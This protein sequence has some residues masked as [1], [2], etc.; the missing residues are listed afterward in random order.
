MPE[1]LIRDGG[2]WLRR[3]MWMEGEGR[4]FG[5]GGLGDYTIGQF[6]QAGSEMFFFDVWQLQT[7][8]RNAG[9]S[10]TVTGAW[11]AASLASLKTLASRWD[12]TFTVD[13]QVGDDTIVVLS[14]SKVGKTQEYTNEAWGI[15]L[16][17]ISDLATRPPPPVAA[18]T[19]FAPVA[20]TTPVVPTAAPAPTSAPAPS[21][22]SVPAWVTSPKALFTDFESVGY[23]EVRVAL[24]AVGF[25]PEN[26]TGGSGQNAYTWDSRTTSAFSRWAAARALGYRIQADVERSDPTLVNPEYMQISPRSAAQA[27]FT[28]ASREANEARLIAALREADIDLADW[29]LAYPKI[30][31]AQ[32]SAAP[33]VSAP[34]PT[35]R[36]A[37]WVL[38]LLGLGGGVVL[39]S[40][41]D[42]K[43]RRRRRR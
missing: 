16:A 9:Y 31:V 5:F 3:T 6:G 12:E 21:V 41:M 40:L 24:K 20:T 23:L 27:L 29:Y 28:E 19:V 35:P 25:F 10:V 4:R 30:T 34:A 1:V 8:L 15:F 11:N 2:P 7:G 36:G 32:P 26:V 37:L 38:G 22:P 17:G 18:P 13:A 43:R 33:P 42:R 39:F 14:G